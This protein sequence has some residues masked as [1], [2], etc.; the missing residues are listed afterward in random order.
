MRLERPDLLALPEQ[1]G[2]KVSKVRRALRALLVLWAQ[3]AATVLLGLL[4]AAATEGLLV[5]QERRAARVPLAQPAR[6]ARPVGRESRDRLGQTGPRA[7][8]ERRVP[9]VRPARRDHQAK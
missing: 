7:L 5:Q 4:A 6:R 8:P 2:C 3:A 1:R 9:S